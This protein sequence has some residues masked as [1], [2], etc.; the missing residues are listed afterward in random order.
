MMGRTIH[1]VSNEKLTNRFDKTSGEFVFE[2][3]VTSVAGRRF[4][5][6]TSYPTC[7]ENKRIVKGCKFARAG[8]IEMEVAQTALKSGA[9]PVTQVIVVCASTVSFSTH[10]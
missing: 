6:V 5:I 2:S 4:L 8:A 7:G 10:G 3:R 9:A 1:P